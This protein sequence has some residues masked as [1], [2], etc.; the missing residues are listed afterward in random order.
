MRI[1][2]ALVVS[3]L[4]SLNADAASF[5]VR[6]SPHLT[7]EA[8][9]LDAPA[10]REVQQK[11]Q[12]VKRQHGIELTVVTLRSLAEYGEAAAN[13]ESYATSLF[14]Q[15]A[16]GD[17]RRNRGGMLLVSKAD[18]RVRIEVSVSYGSGINERLKR[19]IDERITP[20]FRAGEFGGGI[21]SAVDDIIELM[22]PR[23]PLQA[24]LTA[25]APEGSPS[26]EME[27]A[28][29]NPSAG[30][31]EEA[32]SPWFLLGFLV[33]LLGF[34][35][36][37]LAAVAWLV[38]RLIKGTKPRCERCGRDMALL[39]EQEEDPFLQSG[40]KLEEAMG[41]VDYRVWKCSG[42][43]QTRIIPHKRWFSGVEQCP[44]CQ[45]RTIKR[46]TRTEVE[47]GY[48]Q[49]GRQLILRDCGHCG[50]HDERTIIIPQTQSTDHLTAAGLAS[51]SSFS[52]SGSSFSS[53]SSSDSGGSS[54]GGGASG[55]W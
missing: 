51:S 45:H 1:L 23:S 30:Q 9:M 40:Q 3:L 25:E 47:A 55:S 50:F 27:K 6:Q 28:G 26:K 53:S 11:L 35:G 15:W 20:S 12:D 54:S 49:Q 33:I 4:L 13:W 44:G 19:I 10:A 18:R 2:P 34:L 42:C 21:L 29:A 7:D 14:N 38:A 5:P 48:L 31:P 22:V 43:A 37:G 17:S 52:D 24:P 36:S 8:G 16:I 41:S 46:N 32:A 39:T